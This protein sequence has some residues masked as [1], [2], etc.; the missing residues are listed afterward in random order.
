MMQ[1]HL[2]DDPKPRGLALPIFDPRISVDLVF[3]S[4][5]S[6]SPR[7]WREED[8]LRGDRL[9]ILQ[10]SNPES[11]LLNKKMVKNA[12]VKRIGW[13]LLGVVMGSWTLD[14]TF[15]GID[16]RVGTWPR[17]DLGIPIHKVT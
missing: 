10:R 16:G 6:L 2:K 8:A 17:R 12:E 11:K 15:G 13:L 7:R 14:F 9:C 3:L 1:P 5:R 4:H